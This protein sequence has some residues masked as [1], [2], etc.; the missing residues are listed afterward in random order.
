MSNNNELLVAPF[1]LILVSAVIVT[2]ISGTY[3]HWIA[4]IAAMVVLV[5]TLQAMSK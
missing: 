3:L 4:C 1:G 5:W 2:V